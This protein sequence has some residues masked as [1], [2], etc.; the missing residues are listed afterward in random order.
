MASDNDKVKIRGKWEAEWK[1]N[2]EQE[3]EKYQKEKWDRSYRNGEWNKDWEG[4]W[5]QFWDKKWNEGDWNKDWEGYWK[6]FWDI[7]W[8]D[9]GMQKVQPSM[10]KIMA[11]LWKMQGKTSKLIV[12]LA[13]KKDDEEFQEE[14]NDLENSIKS[15]QSKIENK[16]DDLK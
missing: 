7:K 5:K 16:Y 1:T 13:S 15:L 11:E 4:Y 6:Q 9:M 8:N 10:G 12:L 2:W 14:I 3:W